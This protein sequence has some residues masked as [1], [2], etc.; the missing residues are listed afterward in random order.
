MLKLKVNIDLAVKTI[1]KI[2]LNLQKFTAFFGTIH[3]VHLLTNIG[4]IVLTRM[5]NNYTVGQRPDFFVKI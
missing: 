4:S 1:K 2:C 5:K 3:T